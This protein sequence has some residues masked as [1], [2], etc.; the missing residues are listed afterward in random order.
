MMHIFMYTNRYI[1]IYID[2]HTNLHVGNGVGGFSI[3]I[4]PCRVCT[5]LEKLVD[6]LQVAIRPGKVHRRRIRFA[7]QVNVCPELDEP[8]HCGRVALQGSLVDGC[9][10]RVVLVLAVDVSP[11]LDKLVDCDS[12]G[13]TRPCT[14][15]A[16][17]DLLHSHGVLMQGCFPTR[18]DQ[19]Y[20]VPFFLPSKGMHAC[21][22]DVHDSEHRA[23]CRGT[24]SYE[25]NQI[26]PLPEGQHW[27][28]SAGHCSLAWP[29][30]TEPVCT[31]PGTRPASS[32][33]GHSQ[34]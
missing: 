27:H 5:Q 4:L 29:T 31:H 32:S 9:L 16:F 19:S 1:Y 18:S 33:E 21:V 14:S 3:L 24:H 17:H 34:D 28:P 8:H 26:R 23:R 13:Q 30:L 2:T 10:A 12:A 20:F 6:R 11:G 15:G 25:R 7:S 22:R